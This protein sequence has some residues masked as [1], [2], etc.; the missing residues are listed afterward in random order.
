MQ[1]LNP[2][3]PENEL[4]R[5][6]DLSALDL[7]YSN[8]SDSLKDLTQLAA[9]VAGTEISLVNLIDSYTQWSVA[10]HGINLEQMPREDSVCQYTIMENDQ[11]EVPDLSADQRFKDKSYV[12]NPL[13]LRYYFGIPLKS[14]DGLNLGALCLLDSEMK[15]LSPEK[16]ELLKIIAAEVVNR[17]KVYASLNNM[18]QRLDAESETKRKVAHDIRGPLAGIIGLSE[19]VAQQGRTSSLDDILD[20]VQLIHKSS[21]S[22]L[23]L[24]DEILTESKSIREDGPNDFNLSLFKDKLIQ[25]YLPQAQSKSVLFSVVVN[26]IRQS[27]PFSKNK[28]LQITGNLI[29]NAIKFTPAGGYV[30][31]SLDL[32]RQSYQDIL[33][34]AVKDSGLGISDEVV[35]QIL[36]GKVSSTQGTTGEPGY[37]FGLAL[38]RHLVDGLGG[39]LVINSA[40]AEGTE[41]LVT[42]PQKNGATL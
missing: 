16:V 20:F 22:L 40:L 15:K 26:E 10:R 35:G 2:P 5:L 9:K 8:L 30:A 14:E 34:I 41:F 32:L 18:K 38:V 17:I 23:E 1:P 6:L 3:I 28:L 39:A 37:G 11:F 31:V 29:S 21:K 19:I 27:T 13:A 25:L 12:Q 42:I 33:S 36:S 24:A 4:E 7:D